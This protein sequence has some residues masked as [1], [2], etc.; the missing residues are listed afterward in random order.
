VHEGGIASPFIAHWPAVI[1]QPVLTH[2]PGHIIDLMATCLDAA[3]AEYPKRFQG[4]DILPLEGKSLL[5]IFQ[6]KTRARHAALFWEHEGNRAVRQGKWKLVAAQKGAWELYDL[7][8]DRTELHDRAQDHPEKVK[9][10]VARYD[11]WAQRVGVVPWEQLPPARDALNPQQVKPPSA[12]DYGGPGGV[13]PARGWYI[14]HKFDPDTW[15]V[16]VSRDPPG[17]TWKARVL[18]YTTTYRHLA[19]GARPDEL[20]A[21][22]RV[23]LFFAPDEKLRWGYVCHFQD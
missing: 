11:E 10:L 23:N 2:Q 1:R 18:P 15:E 8:T 14:W 19:Y 9:E 7:E 20:R 5:P 22:E 12:R 13:G 21:G 4:R 3:G 6:G 16:E 17:P